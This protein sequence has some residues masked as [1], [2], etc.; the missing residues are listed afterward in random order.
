MNWILIVTY[1]V[2]GNG[3]YLKI[4]EYPTKA[5]CEEMGNRSRLVLR[6]GS[7]DPYY[8]IENVK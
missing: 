8:C 2:M 3:G 5:K 1:I 7:E 6:I 4:G